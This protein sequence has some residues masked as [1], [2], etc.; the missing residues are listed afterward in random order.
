VYP[1]L[2]ARQNG[3]N[4]GRGKAAGS[5]GEEAI[6]QIKIV[7]LIA[8]AIEN[9]KIKIVPDVLVSGGG[10]AGDGLMGQLARVLPG[11]DLGALVKKQGAASVE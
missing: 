10:S 6:K 8:A 5:I 1:S 7:E 9:G 11:V 3:R 4:Q 2:S